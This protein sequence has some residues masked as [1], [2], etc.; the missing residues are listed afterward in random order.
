MEQ[1][2]ISECKKSDCRYYPLRHSVVTMLVDAET[3][4]T[5][6]NCVKI[7]KTRKRISK[8]RK[9]FVKRVKIIKLRKKSLNF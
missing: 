1:G 9:N 5:F 3:R 4:K 6:V 2:Q 8:G 7:T